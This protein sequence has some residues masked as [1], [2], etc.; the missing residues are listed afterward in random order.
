MCDR[1]S[2]HNFKELPKLSPRCVLLVDDAG[3]LFDDELLFYRIP[4]YT[5]YYGANGV[6]Y[7]KRIMSKVTPKDNRIDSHVKILYFEGKDRN[8]ALNYPEYEKV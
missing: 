3:D 2:Y 5:I 7:L 4:L 8:L 1:A 6:D